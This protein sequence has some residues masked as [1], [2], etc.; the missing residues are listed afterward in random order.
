MYV[1][2]LSTRTFDR[3]CRYC[4]KVLLAQTSTNTAFEPYIN[5]QNR[6][7]DINGEDKDCVATPQFV[8]TERAH[9]SGQTGMPSSEVELQGFAN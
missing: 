8:G 1:G 4:E 7:I 6:G 3:T 9:L 2:K 5:I